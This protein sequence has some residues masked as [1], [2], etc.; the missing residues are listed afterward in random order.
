VPDLKIPLEAEKFLAFKHLIHMENILPPDIDLLDDEPGKW[1]RYSSRVT[2]VGG[3]LFAVT[4]L[5]GPGATWSVPKTFNDKA[6]QNC[7][8]VY[9]LVWVAGK[10]NVKVSMVGKQEKIPLVLTTKD[11]P[12]IAV[13]N[14]TIDPDK[15]QEPTKVFPTNHVDHDFKWLYRVVVPKGKES[16]SDTL[17]GKSLPAPVLDAAHTFRGA[18]TAAAIQGLPS[19]TTLEQLLK[20]LTVGSPTCFGGCFGCE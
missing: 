16:W 10:D 13:R 8:G 15:W 14:V 1:S 2:L 6:P 9:A 18:P 7:P 19:S 3:K 12:A 4:G 20:M 5:G 11:C 17:N